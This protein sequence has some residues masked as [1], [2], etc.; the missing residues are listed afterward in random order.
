[1]ILSDTE[2]QINI[3]A[4]FFPSLSDIKKPVYTRAYF[5]SF[6]LEM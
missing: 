1:M 2:I 4:W 5:T 3:K 6:Y